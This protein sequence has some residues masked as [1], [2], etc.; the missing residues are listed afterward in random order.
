[1]P[2]SWGSVTWEGNERL[3]LRRMRELSLREKILAI[4]GLAEVA[5]RMQQLARSR[6]PVPKE[7]T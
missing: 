3:Q 6:K 5:A 7:Q 4:Q 1:M 2:D